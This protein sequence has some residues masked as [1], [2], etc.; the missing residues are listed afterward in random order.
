M[1]NRRC[2]PLEYDI[3]CA[4]W[5]KTTHDLKD[6]AKKI[7]FDLSKICLTGVSQEEM[8]ERD[9]RNEINSTRE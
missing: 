6:R 8:K 3:L 5:D 1:I 7:G 4:E 9:K 2:C